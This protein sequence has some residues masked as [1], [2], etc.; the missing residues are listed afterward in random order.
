MLVLSACGSTENAAKPDLK[1]DITFAQEMVPH[2]QQALEMAKLV[3]DRSSNEKVRG[4]AQRIEKAQD[5]EITRMNGWLK[6]WGAEMKS[7]EG[8]DMAGMMSG[9][10]MAKLEKAT[11]ADFDKQWLD[12]MVQH[13]EGA[14]VMARTELDQGKDA[15]AKKLAQAII[16]GQ[17]QEITEM[18]D[19]LKTM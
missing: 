7:H 5:P 6:E 9:D 8:H 2:H 15:D 10:E 16:D 13:H 18:K 1:A 12:L 19:L 3:P 14:L 11:G 4:L 17:Q